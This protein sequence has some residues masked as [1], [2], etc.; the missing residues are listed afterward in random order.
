VATNFWSVGAAAAIAV[1]DGGRRRAVS[2]QARAAYARSDALYRE[3]VL[4]A[5]REVEDNLA[6]L[7]IL[8]QEATT[9]AAAGTCRGCPCSSPAASHGLL[10]RLHGRA[11]S[12]QEP[13]PLAPSKQCD[14]D[15]APPRQ[16]SQRLAQRNRF[17]SWALGPPPMLH[18]VSPWASSK[19]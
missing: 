13:R 16:S 9:Q 2:D 12:S 10:L 15:A 5:F 3:T 8:E 18:I 19:P 4:V 14:P 17:I 7:R 1:F 11:A 6:A